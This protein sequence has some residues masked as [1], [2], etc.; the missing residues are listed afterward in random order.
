MDIGRE[1]ERE[2]EEYARWLS[3]PFSFLP[4]ITN[5]I[6]MVF[7]PFVKG[8]LLGLLLLFF[9]RFPCSISFPPRS[10]GYPSFF[11][12]RT[13]LNLIDP[14]WNLY[15]I[16]PTLSSPRIFVGMYFVYFFLILSSPYVIFYLKCPRLIYRH[17]PFTLTLADRYIG[18]FYYFFSWSTLTLTTEH[19]IKGS[20]PAFFFL[21]FLCI[22][23]EGYG[24]VG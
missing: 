8:C 23:F 18:A 6:D 3:V 9:E 22:G 12:Q 21:L 15:Y 17:L 24:W 5:L 2:G 11:N 19:W 4:L 10:S 1:R 20:L 7:V 14:L 13:W 16:P